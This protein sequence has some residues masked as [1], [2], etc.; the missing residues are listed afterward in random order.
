LFKSQK[1]VSL[2]I[3]FLRKLFIQVFRIIYT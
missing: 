1:K 3:F 2:E